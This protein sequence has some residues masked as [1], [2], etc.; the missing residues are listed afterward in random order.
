MML[1]MSSKAKMMGM[2]RDN[3]DNTFKILC[4]TNRLSSG[5]ILSRNVF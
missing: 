1:F 4:V 2:K 5:T 3:N